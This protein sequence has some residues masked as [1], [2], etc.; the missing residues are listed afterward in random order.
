MNN[1]SQ[2][3]KRANAVSSSPESPQ[4]APPPP[5]S[6]PPAL[7][8]ARVYS[9][10]STPPDSPPPL[11]QATLPATAHLPDNA[12]S[13]SS[14]SP[15]ASYSPIG[16]HLVPMSS[17]SINLGN[18][19]S[20][21][22]S[23]RSGTTTYQEQSQGVGFTYVHTTPISHSSSNSHGTNFSYSSSS[24]NNNF[25]NQ[26]LPN[27]NT[28]SPVLHQ[29]HLQESPTSPVS[30]I[31]IS[32]RHSISHISH[33]QSYSQNQQSSSGGPPSPASS[34]SVSSHT[35][36]PPTPTYNVFHDD[37]HTYHH[38]SNMIPDQPGLANG[39]ISSQGQ[40][41]HPGYSPTIS[42]Q[43]TSLPNSP[44]DSPPPILAPIQD[45]RVMRRDE[46]RHSQIQS[47]HSTSPYIHHPQPLPTEYQ[48]HQSLGLGHGAWKSDSGLRS[49]GVG[50]L[51]Q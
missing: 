42:V 40:L 29:Q 11:A 9:H 17:Q 10:H 50:A 18:Q 44:F 37:A 34:H 31:S 22:Y 48:Y 47:H 25:D 2:P 28:S 21:S 6:S 1:S 3:T 13:R 46:Q 8:P 16:H 41:V 32:S 49:K 30:S 51:V 45:E 12:S 24:H 7:E 27:L 43:S 33:P 39:H 4:S 14:S 5:L 23:Y 19:N 35:S 38:G 20:H 26:P 15:E 36:G